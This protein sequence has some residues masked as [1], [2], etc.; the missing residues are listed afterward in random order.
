V[1]VGGKGGIATQTNWRSRLCGA[2]KNALLR[3]FNRSH[4]RLLDVVSGNERRCPSWAVSHAADTRGLAV[5]I[6]I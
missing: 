5:I 6:E 1:L 2:I 4:A 3:E